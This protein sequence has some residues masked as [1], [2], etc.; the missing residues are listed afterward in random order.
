MDD[1]VLKDYVIAGGLEDLNEKN[2]VLRQLQIRDGL[3]IHTCNDYKNSLEV[4]KEASFKMKNKLKIITK[5]YYKYPNVKHRR[6]RSLFS[7]IEEQFNRLGFIPSQWQLQICCYC[8]LNQLV[9]KNAQNFFWKINKE[10]GIN[11]IFL[12]TYP[13][14]NFD[15]NKVNNLNEFYKGNIIFGLMG[16]QNLLNRIFDDRCLAKYIENSTEL[17]FIGILGKGIQN[18]LVPKNHNS[19]FINKNIIYFLD[20]INKFKLIKGI[21]NF[22]SL[23]QYT[24]FSSNFQKFQDLSNRKLNENAKYLCKKN[25]FYFRSFDQYGGYFSIK[26]YIIKPK[27]IFFKIKNIIL[28]FIKARKFSNN[29]FG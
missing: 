16:Y 18:K 25:I 2:I 17:I 9:S 22:S 5:V 12:E 6:F 29:F 20:N 8:P 7:Q 14:Y 28:S 26:Q 4:I 21:T 3:T 15:N 1:L 23:K 13:L 19:D 11:K 27:L 10:F 24:N